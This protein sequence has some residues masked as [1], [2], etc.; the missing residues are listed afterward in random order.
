MRATK[1]LRGIVGRASKAIDEGSRSIERTHRATADKP[2]AALAAMPTVVALP[3]RGVK[4]AHDVS[5]IAV[6][7]A[8]RIANQGV[9]AIAEAG[10]DLADALTGAEPDEASPRERARDSGR[11]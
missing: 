2:F 4:L 8:V 7:G 6:Y 11:A 9:A 5:L 3:A 10:L 1:A